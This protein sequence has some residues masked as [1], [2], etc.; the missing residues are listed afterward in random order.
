VF[1]PVIGA[2]TWV[3]YNIGR[4]ALQQIKRINQ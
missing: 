1:I 3:V 4:V 2:A